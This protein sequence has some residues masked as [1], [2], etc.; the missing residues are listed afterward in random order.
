MYN[1]SLKFKYQIPL[2]LF[3]MNINE[4][5]IKSEFDINNQI[6]IENS[7]TILL[8]FEGIV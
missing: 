7:L 6:S 2:N 8:I 3:E 1:D 4:V 5:M